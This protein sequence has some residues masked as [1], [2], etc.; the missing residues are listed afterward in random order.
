M[1]LGISFFSGF[2]Y[3]LYDDLT[4]NNIPI[5]NLTMEFV[6]VF[7]VASTTLLMVN[8]ADLTLLVS[9]MSVMCY[10][11]NQ[12]D[13][14]FWKAWSSLPFLLLFYHLPYFTT[15]AFTDIGIRLLAS[16]LG[17]GVI[18][19]EAKLFPEEISL[20]K[21]SSRLFMC[22]ALGILSYFCSQI[23]FDY[24]LPA[25][26]F[27][28]GYFFS[29]VVFHTPTIYKHLQEGVPFENEETTQT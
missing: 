4:D 12:V 2:I 18:F 1:E 5:S 11:C 7:L 14:D 23:G 26:I 13:T 28:T 27:F 16:S 10:V 22:I 21:Y 15:L 17:L 24:L 25:F 20:R 9:I 8:Y 6:K 3:K 29:S 19:L